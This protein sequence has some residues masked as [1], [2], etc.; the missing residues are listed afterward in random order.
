MSDLEKILQDNTFLSQLID[1]LPCGVLIIDE[2]GKIMAFNNVIDHIFSAENAKLTG[3][4]FGNA[5][6]VSIPVM[7]KMNVV[8]PVV[9]RAAGSANWL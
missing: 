1:A 8:P 4:G 9:V 7:I 3:K 2:A 5:F 6:A